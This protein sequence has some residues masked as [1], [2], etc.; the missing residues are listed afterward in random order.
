MDCGLTHA[1]IG[2]FCVV[3]FFVGRRRHVPPPPL[4]SQIFV[5]FCVLCR[6]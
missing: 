3:D 1:P 2:V 5:V 4:V 6:L